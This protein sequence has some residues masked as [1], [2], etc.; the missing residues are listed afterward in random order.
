MTDESDKPAAAKPP[1]K[2][3]LREMRQRIA[4]EAY[5]KRFHHAVMVKLATE[6]GEPF[7]ANP[8]EIAIAEA[9][10]SAVR[11]LEW[12]LRDDVALARLQE[13]AQRGEV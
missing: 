13:V 12:L 9:F 2:V 7:A 11:V 10:E 3:T 1:R 6:E 8:E 4:D 5:S